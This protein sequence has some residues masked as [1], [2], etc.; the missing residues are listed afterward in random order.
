MGR[1]GRFLILALFIAGLLLAGCTEIAT[2]Q[3]GPAPTATATPTNT[4]TPRGEFSP[5]LELTVQYAEMG[6][7]LTALAADGAAAGARAAR[8]TAEAEEDKANV[9]VTRAWD[10][11]TAQAK[12]TN[13]EIARKVEATRQAQEAQ[14]TQ[15]AIEAEGTRQALASEAT[16]QAMSQN[17][18]AT[19]IAANTTSTAVAAEYTRQAIAGYA[20]ATA[21]AVVQEIELGILERER[22]DLARDRAWQ[23]LKTVVPWLLLALLL[24]AVGWVG[25]NYVV[26]WRR[27]QRIIK[28]DA[29]GDAPLYL[30]PG[31]KG[32]DGV[33]IIDVDRSPGPVTV[34]E[35]DV[36]VVPEV[37]SPGVQE[38][39]TARD[40]EVDRQ[41]RSLPGQQAKR[42]KRGSKRG[43]LPAPGRTGKPPEIE[44]EVLT[45]PPAEVLGW[46]DEVL[47]KMLEDGEDENGQ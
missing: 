24:V 21:V 23:S 5:E 29:R 27:R 1:V 12:A 35:G 9:E 4:A 10:Q 16:A 3:A 40:Q 42:P 39:T 32:S 28:R 38:R 34:V 14:A 19:Q 13:D 20:T 22:L 41:T 47:P 26:A 36:I 7:H 8:E 45:D 18:T 43:A 46:I 30:A 33:R 15:Q 25:Y 2:Q 37:A 44:I 6:V 11:A 17:A 31:Q